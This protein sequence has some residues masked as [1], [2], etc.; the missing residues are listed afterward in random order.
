MITERGGFWVI[1]R[2]ECPLMRLL[3][4]K[5]VVERRGHGRGT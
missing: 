1:V 4:I 3:C 5:R 2:G